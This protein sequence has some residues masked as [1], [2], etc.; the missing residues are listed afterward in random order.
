MQQES[1]K[2]PVGGRVVEHLVT[3]EIFNMTIILHSLVESY[4]IW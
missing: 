4:M 3:L 1:I 2:A